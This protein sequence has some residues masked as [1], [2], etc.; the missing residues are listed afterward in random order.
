M[1]RSDFL[2]WMGTVLLAAVVAAFL[3]R[4]L[5]GERWFDLYG[6]AT[7]AIP[8]ALAGGV[9]LAER[10]RATGRS[11][12]RAM[13]FAAPL[14]AFA[15][16]QIGYWTSVVTLGHKAVPLLLVRGMLRDAGG[17]YLVLVPAAIVA[18]LV[19]LVASAAAERDKPRTAVGARR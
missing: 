15:A 18:A 17:P 8:T 14:L 1:T 5:A 16:V 3:L 2:G 4:P 13:M 6:L 11:P 9:I 19:W 7:V 12:W 10:Y